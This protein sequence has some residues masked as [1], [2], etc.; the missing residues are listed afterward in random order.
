LSLDM[1]EINAGHRAL[2]REAQDT[3]RC[4]ISMRVA[5]S[6]AMLRA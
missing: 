3:A 6:G 5:R 2:M 4:V 1:I